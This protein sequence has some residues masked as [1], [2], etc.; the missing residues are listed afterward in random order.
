M[1]KGKLHGKWVKLPDKITPPKS[2]EKKVFEVKS[3]EVVPIVASH[4][5]R[6]LAPGNFSGEPWIEEI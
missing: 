3:Y 4:H 6:N 2:G 1:E 5:K